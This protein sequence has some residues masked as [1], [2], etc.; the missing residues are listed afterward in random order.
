MLLIEARRAVMSLIE[1]RRAVFGPNTAL[2]ASPGI[3]GNTGNTR[4]YTPFGLSA[5]SR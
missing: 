2:R 3:H 5:K 4:E 1:A